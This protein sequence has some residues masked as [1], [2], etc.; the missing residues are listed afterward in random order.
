MRM[1]A[2]LG[3]SRASAAA[4]GPGLEEPAAG[5]WQLQPT[6]LFGSLG[7]ELP[8]RSGC[9]AA[10][11]LFPA[12]RVSAVSPQGGQ[13]GGWGGCPAPP[14]VCPRSHAPAW[15]WG[16]ERLRLL[17]GTCCH[18][19]PA[20]PLCWGCPQGVRRAALGSGAERRCSPYFSGWGA[21]GERCCRR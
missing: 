18:P 11:L 5:R 9:A 1:A 6:R 7:P 2:A 19:L 21:P 4:L 8:L 16:G 12:P 13:A 10:A 14:S 15:R 20:F 17:S 3:G